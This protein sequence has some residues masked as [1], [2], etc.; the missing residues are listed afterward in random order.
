[1][2]DNYILNLKDPIFPDYA[3]NKKYVDDNF[4]E[5][6]GGTLTG[7]INMNNNEINNLGNSPSLKSP[8]TKK[9]VNDTFFPKLGGKL[10]GILDMNNR[11]INNIPDIRYSNSSAVNKKYVDHKASKI[12][13]YKELHFKSVGRSAVWGHVVMVGFPFMP[14]QILNP[15]SNMVITILSISSDKDTRSSKP[16]GLLD[17]TIRIPM[18]SYADYRK[19]KSSGDTTISV[20][21]MSDLE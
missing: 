2:N 6:S 18:R 1:M 17:S 3:T 12:T 20:F 10:Q 11:N 16:S 15:N 7:N 4:L 9:Y 8:V 19:T 14:L 13:I 21:K 5:K